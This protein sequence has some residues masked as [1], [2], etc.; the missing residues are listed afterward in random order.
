MHSGLV[1]FKKIPVA[2]GSI[3][4]FAL[5][6]AWSWLFQVDAAKISSSD[7]VNYVVIFAAYVLAVGLSWL[8]LRS[9]WRFFKLEPRGYTPLGIMQFIVLWAALEHA[10]AWLLNALVMGS[11]GSWDSLLPFTSLTPL[12]MHTPFG[13][14]VRLFGYFGT[15]AVVVCGL[16]ILYRKQWK[17]AAGYWAIVT[18]LT[19]CSW[20]VYRVP[21]EETLNV[22]VV[23]ESVEE[24]A[25]FEPGDT[26]FVLFPEYGLDYQDLNPDKNKTIMNNVEYSGSKTRLSDNLKKANTIVYGKFNEENTALEQNKQRLIPFGEYL[27]WSVEAGL[28]AFKPEVYREFTAE[29]ATK[30]G[31]VPLKVHTHGKDIIIGNAVCSS[32]I[33]PEDYRHLTKQGATILANSASLGILN[34]SPVYQ[35]YHQGFAAFMAVSNARPFL[36]SAESW[37]AFILDHNGRVLHSDYPTSTISSRIHINTKTTP[38]TFLGEWVAL[39][40]LIFMIVRVIMMLATN[41]KIKSLLP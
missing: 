19:F 34:N 33:N 8:I 17:T 6:I 13:F 5:I 21:S 28:K 29:R 11:D 26:D 32:I 20:A 18:L 2:P 36:Q 12:I 40:G 14:I 23:S 38:Y 25:T 24:K 15:S 35:F 7:T 30:R 41:R 39:I 3:A 1:L 10:L 37:S 27:P 9:G 22:T 4:L 16:L 31:E